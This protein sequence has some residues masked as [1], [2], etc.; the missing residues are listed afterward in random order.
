MGSIAFDLFQF[1]P[2]LFDGFDNRYHSKLDV[3]LNTNHS[4]KLIGVSGLIR[5][6]SISY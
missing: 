3:L 1:C 6:Y 2:V 4:I 5:S